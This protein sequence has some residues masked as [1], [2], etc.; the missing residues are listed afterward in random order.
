M[1]LLDSVDPLLDRRSDHDVAGALR[2]LDAERYHR[3]AIEPRKRAPIGNGVGDCAE[4][5][6]ANLTSGR[7]ADHGARELVE[8]PRTGE[9]ADRLVV[10]ANLGAAAGDVD[11]GPAEPVADI[12]RGQADRL[13][14]V[15]IE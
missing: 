6:E 3:L 9:R 11:V 7:Q 8:R 12:D 2:S 4:I 10:L 1:R 5:V 15:G 13:Q 14:A